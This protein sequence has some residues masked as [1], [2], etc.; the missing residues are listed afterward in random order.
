MS[1]GLTLDDLSMPLRA[2][3]LLTVDFG[4]L[5]APML[6]LSTIF[7]DRLKLAFHYDLADF[8]AWREALGIAPDTVEH[9]TQ[10]PDGGTRVLKASIEYAGAVLE[11]VA[12][13]DMPDPAL[14]GAA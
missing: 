4:H 3:R 12:Y 10:G 9:G 1:E 6:D 11:L 13:A 7:P 14:T 2:L 8:E 5:P